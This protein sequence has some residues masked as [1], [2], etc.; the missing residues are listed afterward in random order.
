MKQFSLR[1]ALVC[2][3]VALAFA[4][5]TFDPESGEGFVGK[6]DVQLVFGWNNAQL[7]ANANSVEFRANT[8]VVSEVSWTCTNSNNQNEQI[9]ERTTTTSIQGVVDSIARLKNQI[10]GFN[11]EGYDP[12]NST[13]SSQTDGPAL[14]SCPSGP[15]SL[16]TPAGDPEVVSSTSALQVSINGTDW[17]DL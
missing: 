15:W 5:V 3:V 6:G 13:E 9:R 2:A 12:D 1:A 8:T 11:L 10:T 17:F 16:T 14:N 4:A 7:Q